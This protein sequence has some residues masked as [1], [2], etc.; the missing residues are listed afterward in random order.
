MV[1]YYKQSGLCYSDAKELVDWHEEIMSAKDH[2]WM[3]TMHDNLPG[4]VFRGA[5]NPPNRTE[6]NKAAAYLRTNG[7]SWVSDEKKGYWAILH[8]GE[9]IS[10]FVIMFQ[11][12]SL[13]KC[14]ICGEPLPPGYRTDTDTHAMCT[15]ISHFEGKAAKQS[16]VQGAALN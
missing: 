9:I 14:R 3:S 16:T 5:Q 12:P 2:W 6:Q 7:W 15:V 10:R 8:K 11:A 13:G 1:T 4:W